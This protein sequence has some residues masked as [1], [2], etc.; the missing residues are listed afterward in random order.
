MS[1]KPKHRFWRGKVLPKLALTVVPLPRNTF[2]SIDVTN[3]CNLRCRHCYYFSYDQDRGPEL[4]VDEWLARIE[5]MQAGRGA[6][7]SCTWV[8]G[9]PL[10]RRELI[11]RGKG[12]FRANRVVTNGTLPLPE[13]PDVEFHVSIDGT[14]EQHDYIRGE[15]CYD[16]IMKNI[17][18]GRC[19]GLN[20]AVACCL[21]RSNAGSIERILSE[22]REIPHIRHVLFDFMTPVRGVE[23]G[24]WI[25]FPERHEI[26]DR[27]EALRDTYGSFIGGPPGTFDLMRL[28][29]KSSCVGPNCVFVKNGTAF[30]AWGNVKKPCVIGPNADCDRCG[31]IVPFSLRAWKKPSNLLREIFRDIRNRNI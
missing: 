10:L 7:F 28:E 29:N 1:D 12:L 22:L 13:W 31:C 2:C 4:S 3:R 14:R 24:M 27:L 30:D 26:I 16:R 15:G 17:R 25:T 21:N 23:E 9:E 5:R 8:G 20:I 19:E 6:F 18:D 11:E